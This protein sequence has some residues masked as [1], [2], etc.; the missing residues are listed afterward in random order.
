M[1]S[2]AE[3]KE[4]DKKT[5]NNNPLETFKDCA[6]D[7]IVSFKNE[8]IDEILE[9]LKNEE[10][11]NEYKINPNYYKFQTEINSKSWRKNLKCWR[12]NRF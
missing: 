2:K 10:I 7:S 5:E 3:Y 9:N 4:I 8:Y 6:E 11:N 1:L 12:K